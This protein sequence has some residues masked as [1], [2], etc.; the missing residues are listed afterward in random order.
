MRQGIFPANRGCD[1]HIFHKSLKGDG[2][3]GFAICG[4]TPLDGGA[5]V[6]FGLSYFLIPVSY[7]LM[8][9]DYPLTGFRHFPLRISGSSTRFSC[10]LIGS[11]YYLFGLSHSSVVPVDLN[12]KVYHGARENF[13]AFTHVSRRCWV[14]VETLVGVVEK[15][16]NGKPHLES[17]LGRG[18]RLQRP[19]SAQCWPTSR[20]C[21]YL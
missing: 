8:G 16:L 6:C 14:V 10:S 15:L 4:L 12:R 20:P 1:P 9:L 7:P 5:K 3:I 2:S 13:V 18:R 19:R 21:L 17:P 11:S